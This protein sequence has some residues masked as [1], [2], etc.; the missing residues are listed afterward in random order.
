M[1]AGQV[2]IE[3]DA[4]EKLSSV[5][6][7]PTRFAKVMVPPVR[8]REPGPFT[9]FPKLI[10]PLVKFELSK[11]FATESIEIVPD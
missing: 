2:V 6:P 11:K 4:R 5:E 1:L 10:E 8:I 9:V 3:P 7:L